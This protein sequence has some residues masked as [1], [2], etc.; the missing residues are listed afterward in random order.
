M[1]FIL[2]QYSVGVYNFRHIYI[3]DWIIDWI[4]NKTWITFNSPAYYCISG[5]S[6]LIKIISWSLAINQYFKISPLLIVSTVCSLNDS[7]HNRSSWVYLPTRLKS[8]TFCYQRILL[9]LTASSKPT[10]HIVTYIIV[11]ICYVVNILKLNF[12]LL[13]I[14]NK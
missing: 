4:G 11:I 13:L 10:L 6:G 14:L 5:Y 12:I 2:F 3:H 7:S 9:S 8:L 1:P